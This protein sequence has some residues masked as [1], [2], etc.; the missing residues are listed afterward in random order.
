MSETRSR[1]RALVAWAL[2]LAGCDPALETVDG[3]MDAGLDATFEDVGVDSPPSRDAPHIDAADTRWCVPRDAGLHVPGEIECG[4]ASC[5]NATSGCCTYSHTGDFANDCRVA[6]CMTY[7]EADESSCPSFAACRFR[8]DCAAGE[9][10]CVHRI[11]DPM[12]PLGVRGA[13]LC[14]SAMD[15]TCEGTV[16]CR[17]DVDCLPPYPHCITVE[18]QEGSYRVCAPM[19][20]P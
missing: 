14:S 17:S 20:A 16:G 10:C 11:P 4:P 7:E 6:H 18:W 5:P 12:A 1:A 15:P 9:L 2:A 3:G 8:E 19:P 13:S